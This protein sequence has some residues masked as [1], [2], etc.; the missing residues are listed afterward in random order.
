MPAMSRGNNGE[1]AGS[2]QP[3]AATHRFFWWERTRIDLYQTFTIILL[4]NYRCLTGV[5]GPRCLEQRDTGHFAGRSEEPAPEG[6]IS[7]TTAFVRDIY[8]VTGR[9]PLVLPDLA[10]RSF[11]RRRAFLFRRR[12]KGV[13]VQEKDPQSGGISPSA[14]AAWNPTSNSTKRSC[15][16]ASRMPAMS[17]W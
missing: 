13:F 9:S 6:R 17:S 11:T 10:R 3:A 1:L 7:A 8:P 12:K 2:R 5:V 16:I 15:A 4:A 14:R